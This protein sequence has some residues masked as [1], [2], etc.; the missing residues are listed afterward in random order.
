MRVLHVSSGN[1]YGGIEVVLS[2]LARCRDLAPSLDQR[3]ALCYEGR[4]A[5]EL[6]EAGAPPEILGP[7]RF[8]RPWTILRARRA[9]RRA[10]ATLRPDAVICH[11][12]W[13]HALFAPVARRSGVP[14]VSWQ[15]DMIIDNHWI[16]RLASRT[17]PDLALVNSHATARTTARLFPGVRSEVIYYPVAP[18]TIDDPAGVRRDLRRELGTPE[19]A[20]VIAMTCRLEPYKG[21]AL[22]ID[23][24]GRLRDVPGWAA[25]VAGGVQRPEDRAYLDGLTRRAEAAGVAGRVEFIGQRS[26]VPR[27]LASADVHCQP[28]ARGEPFGIAFVEALYAGLPVVTTRMGGA[29]EIVTEECGILVPPADPGALAGALRALIGDPSRRASLSRGGPSRARSLCDPGAVLGRL[30]TLLAGVGGGPR[31]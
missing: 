13:P 29:E 18:A 9:L 5:G 21:H 28:N 1:L 22:L 20:V 10:I 7:A 14:L 16:N 23:A 19:G 6:R 3:F 11:A 4:I 25:W 15:H 24:L 2:T 27:V 26:D 17:A 31:P 8:G 12:C 30:S